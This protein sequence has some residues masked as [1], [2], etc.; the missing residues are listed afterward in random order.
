MY[1]ITRLSRFV[2][3]LR[4]FFLRTERKLKQKSRRALD[5]VSAQSQETL[6]GTI[7]LIFEF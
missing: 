6:K 1:E 5:E 2:T 3:E 4:Q 7:N